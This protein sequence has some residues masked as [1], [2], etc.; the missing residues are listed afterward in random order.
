MLDLY[1]DVTG[2]GLDSQVDR[3]NNRV[4]AKCGRKGWTDG[5]LFLCV[6]GHSTSRFEYVNG[7]GRIARLVK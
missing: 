3:H 4:G 2:K 1:E 7:Q 5:Q 6:L